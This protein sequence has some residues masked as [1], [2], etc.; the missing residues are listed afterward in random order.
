MGCY[1]LTGHASSLPPLPYKPGCA[2]KGSGNLRNLLLLTAGESRKKS[3]E[4][5]CLI[6]SLRLQCTGGGVG[7]SSF[8]LITS[9][10]TFS[11]KGRSDSLNGVISWTGT[12]CSVTCWVLLTWRRKY[13]TAVNGLANGFSL[14]L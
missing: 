3:V 7:G 8:S 12:D 9:T 2:W 10:P 1:S 14:C 13:P 11:G 4:C 5:W 6:L